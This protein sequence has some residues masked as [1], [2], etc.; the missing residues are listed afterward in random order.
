MEQHQQ[1]SDA[2]I[3]YILNNTWEKSKPEWLLADESEKQQTLDFIKNRLRSTLAGG[4]SK[5]WKTQNNEPIGILGAYKIDIDRYETFF[6]C[7]KHM[8]EHSLKLSF[9]MRTILRDLA[10]KY[11]GYA[12]GQ[13][14]E[15]HRTDQRSWFRFLGFTYKP[16]G[17]VANRLY[18]EFVSA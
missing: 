11:K 1:I 7:S 17:N 16:E 9:D 3:M 13:Y 5:I 8:E 15:V 18:F 10:V 12:L 14:A 4:Y 2:D 6:I